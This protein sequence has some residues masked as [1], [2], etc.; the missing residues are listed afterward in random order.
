MRGFAGLCGIGFA[1]IAGV[2]EFLV[3]ACTAS[4]LDM[5]A[6]DGNAA[7]AVG[8]P[9]GAMTPSEK[10]GH[11]GTIENQRMTDLRLPPS[12]AR[13][14]FEKLITRI[15]WP[16]G[17]DGTDKSLFAYGPSAKK[18]T[19]GYS[20]QI[21]WWTVDLTRVA[22]VDV[23]INGKRVDNPRDAKQAHTAIYRL[24]GQPIPGYAGAEGFFNWTIWPAGNFEFDFTVYNDAGNVIGTMSHRI[25]VARAPTS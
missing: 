21:I 2:L 22:A 18:P 13:V 16:R 17:Q 25:T 1:A 8:S 11:I 7:A 5:A 23:A 10:G 6:M 9:S 24:G 14:P 19:Q 3:T 20:S 12:A 4:P 15:N